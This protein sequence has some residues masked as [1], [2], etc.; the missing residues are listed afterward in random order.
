MKGRRGR[1]G[2]GWGRVKEGEGEGGEGLLGSGRRWWGRVRDASGM[3][4]SWRHQ[5]GHCRPGD[6]WG[7]GRSAAAAATAAVAGG[8][9]VTQRGCRQRGD[10]GQMRPTVGRERRGDSTLSPPLCPLPHSSAARSP[11]PPLSLPNPL[12]PSW[13][14]QSSELR[15][16]LL[17]LAPFSAA[18]SDLF[19]RPAARLLEALRCRY[20]HRSSPLTYSPPYSMLTY[21]PHH[22]LSPRSSSPEQCALVSLFAVLS[23]RP[24]YMRRP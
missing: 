15:A 8:A 12:P 3:G 7:R 22:L 5:P 16:Q 1:G 6:A 9:V 13:D 18:L 11:S 23:P 17:P 2:R 24:S 14:R 19:A 21:S 4:R 20:A 10:G